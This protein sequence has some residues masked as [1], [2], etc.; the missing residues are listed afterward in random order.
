MEKHYGE[1]DGAGEQILNPRAAD[2]DGHEGSYMEM[3][4]TR[5]KGVDSTI[6]D[7]KAELGDG[8][9]LIIKEK[10]MTHGQQYAETNFQVDL[11]GVDSTANVVSRSVAKGDFPPGVQFQNLR[12]QP[13]LRTYGM[14]CDSD[15]RGTRGQRF[16]LWTP[17]T[18]T[19]V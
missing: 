1:G 6:R 2:V 11:N 5:I 4:T 14:R 10:I 19:P 17:I 12:K 18:W 8:A 13:V 9:T 16:R 15:G 7:T 3:E